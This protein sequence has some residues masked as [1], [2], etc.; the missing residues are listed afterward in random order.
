MIQ[1]NR[2]QIAKSLIK[3]G[4]PENIVKKG[5]EAVEDYAQK[6]SINLPAKKA[7]HKPPMPPPP[8]R[9]P[10]AQ[11]L[12]LGIPIS[13]I[14]QGPDAVKEF[15]DKHDITL[16]PREHPQEPPKGLDLMA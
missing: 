3:A 2:H 5:P 12:S 8:P 4:I 11:L 9:P 13:I 10:I 1:I 6:H 7:E 15:A 14:L 16:P